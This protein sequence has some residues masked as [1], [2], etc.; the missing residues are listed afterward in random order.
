MNGISSP[1]NKLGSVAWRSS[2]VYLI[3]PFKKDRMAEIWSRSCNL[4]SVLSFHWS[5]RSEL[6][7]SFSGACT[8]ILELDPELAPR[9]RMENRR[10]EWAK[11]EG[12][13]LMGGDGKKG[14]ETFEARSQKQSQKPTPSFTRSRTRSLDLVSNYPW[15]W[16]FDLV[17]DFPWRWVWS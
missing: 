6:I 9:L 3:L 14:T 10:G 11:G 17:S 4:E 15:N 7:L 13:I 8:R 2:F 12:V 5:R 16:S 1:K